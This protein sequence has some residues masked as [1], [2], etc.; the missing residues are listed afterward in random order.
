MTFRGTGM[1]LGSRSQLEKWIVDPLWQKDNALSYNTS[2]GEGFVH[3]RDPG[4]S[5]QSASH[6]HL[7]LISY[8]EACDEA[9]RC[10]ISCSCMRHASHHQPCHM[11]RCTGQC[12]VCMPAMLQGSTLTTEMW[13]WSRSSCQRTAQQPADHPTAHCPVCRSVYCPDDNNHKHRT[14]IQTLK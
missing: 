9:E 10:G 12:L 8:P 3:W 1:W 13:L 6:H 7:S 14:F 11:V 4:T 2:E 5:T